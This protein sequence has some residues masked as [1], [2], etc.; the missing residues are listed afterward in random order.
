RLGSGGGGS[1]G[2]H[3][4]EPDARG[5]NRRQGKERGAHEGRLFSGFGRGSP[6]NLMLL[7][8]AAGPCGS[9]ARQFTRVAR[10]GIVHSRGLPPGES[11]RSGIEEGPQFSQ[12]QVQVLYHFPPAVVATGEGEVVWGFSVTRQEQKSGPA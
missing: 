11:Q 6:G 1:Q 2:G 5:A 8:P 7:L 4:G 12:K 3:Q 10:T 9:N